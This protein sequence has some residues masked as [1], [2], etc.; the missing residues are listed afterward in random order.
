VLGTDS[1][2]TGGAISTTLTTREVLVA[3]CFVEI[4]LKLLRLSLDAMMSNITSKELCRY[5]NNICE[6]PL[7]SAVNFE[8]N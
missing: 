1:E 8:F 2:P 6:S 3:V 7:P 5:P 4:Q